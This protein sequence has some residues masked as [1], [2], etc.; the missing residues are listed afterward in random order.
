MKEK[1]ITKIIKQVT[2]S[3]EGVTFTKEDKEILKIEKGSI[4]EV[5]KLE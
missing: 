1:T 4:V 3:A 2:G 5:K